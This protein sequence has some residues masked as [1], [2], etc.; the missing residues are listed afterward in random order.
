MDP[1]RRAFYQFHASLIEPWDGPA[2]VAFSDGT[3]AGAV[4]DRNGLRPGRWLRDRRTTWSCSRA[5]PAC[6][7][8]IRPLWWPAA[9]CSRAGCSWSTRRPAGS[10]ATTRSRPHSPPRSRTR[11]GCTPGLMHLD[12]LPAREHVV[13]THDSVRRRQQTFGYTDEELK[14]LLAPMARDRLRTD[15]LDGHRHADRRPVEAT[16]AALRLLHAD[17][18]PGHEPAA[19][20]DPGRARHQHVDH[21]RARGEPARA[22]PGE[23]SPDRAAVPGDRQRRPREDPLDRRRRRPARLQGDPGLRPL[24]RRRRRSPGCKARIVEICR[25]VSEAIDDGV[26]VLVLSDRD[27]TADLA[28]IPSLLLTAAVHQHLVRERTRTQVAL[29]VETGDCSRGAPRRDADRL[30]RRRGQPVPGAGERRRPDRDRCDHRR[31]PGARRPTT[32]WSRSARAS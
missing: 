25:H 29:I 11:S 6:S 32:S 15:R 24:P 8:S 3:L 23:L 30:R 20:L 9:G 19:G 5:S 31:Q 18:R 28:P 16:P 10:S 26:R 12:E 1:D 13:Y 27:S 17:V 4:L 7:T 14:I 21:D 22:G 2:A